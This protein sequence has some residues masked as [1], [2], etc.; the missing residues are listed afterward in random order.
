MDYEMATRIRREV[1]FVINSSLVI[2]H[3]SFF[4]P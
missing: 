4:Y 2:R 3:S 1:I